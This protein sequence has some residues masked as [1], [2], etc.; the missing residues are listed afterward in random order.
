MHYLISA[1]HFY[2]KYKRYRGRLTGLLV[3]TSSTLLLS[4]GSVEGARAHVV[5]VVVLAN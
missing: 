5:V 4:Q 2:S 1:E 3:T